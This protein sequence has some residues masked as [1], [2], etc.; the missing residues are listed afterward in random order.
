M[1]SRKIALAALA[2]LILWPATAS[3]Q[4]SLTAG[5]R[6]AAQQC[7]VCHAV[8]Q[9]DQSPNPKSPRFRDLGAR[10]PFDGLRD[11][12]ATGMIVGH[13]QMP[14]LSLTKVEIDDLIAYLKTLQKPDTPARTTRPLT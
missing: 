6:L 4:T 9:R 14:V 7:G 8:D 10:Y 12:L 3:A 1:R 2:A 5:H 13:A 11:A